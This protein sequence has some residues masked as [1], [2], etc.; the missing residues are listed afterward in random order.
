MHYLKCYE[1]MLKNTVTYVQILLNKMRK[2]TQNWTVTSKQFNLLPKLCLRAHGYEVYMGTLYYSR[3]NTMCR[4]DVCQIGKLQKELRQRAFN[5]ENAL[6]Y[7]K[8]VEYEFDVMYQQKNTNAILAAANEIMNKTAEQAKDSIESTEAAAKESSKLSTIWAIGGIVVSLL[9][10]IISLWYS[11]KT[12]KESSE[13]LKT[14]RE[15]LSISI[16]TLSGVISEMDNQVEQLVQED[17][18]IENIKNVQ[19]TLNEIDDKLTRINK[20]VSGNNK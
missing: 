2:Q 16:G 5:I 18:M 15:E 10:G 1:E 3:Y 17:Y 8:A 9:L 6:R 19:G 7:I 12:A 13:E 11:G 20:I 14:V 4:T